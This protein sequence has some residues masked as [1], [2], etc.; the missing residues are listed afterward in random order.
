MA[1]I[2]LPQVET[3]PPNPDHANFWLHHCKS[4]WPSHLEPADIIIFYR[5]DIQHDMQNSHNLEES[6]RET[7]CLGDVDKVGVLVGAGVDINSQNGVNGWTALHWAA[8]RSHKHVVSFL[9][10]SGANP[11]IRSHKNEL[12][13][14]VTQSKEIKRLL[15]GEESE[16]VQDNGDADRLSEARPGKQ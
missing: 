3:S 9:L 6:L 8:K 11:T 2:L 13:V 1:N 7:A 10:Q 12:A 15:S 14:N 5:L 16:S 4:W